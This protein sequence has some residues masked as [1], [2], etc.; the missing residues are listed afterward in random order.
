MHIPLYNSIPNMY[1]KAFYS[2]LGPVLDAQQYSDNPDDYADGEHF[3]HYGAEVVSK[4]LMSSID[5]YLR[6]L[7]KSESCPNPAESR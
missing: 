1:D 3:N 2:S 6:P 7:E 5:P 4:W